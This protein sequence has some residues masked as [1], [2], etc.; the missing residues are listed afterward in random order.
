MRSI[1]GRS[2]RTPPPD[3]TVYQSFTGSNAPRVRGLECDRMNARY[4]YLQ[5]DLIGSEWTSLSVRQALQTASRELFG[6]A[7]AALPLDVLLVEHSPTGGPGRALV[8]V[9]CGSLVKTRAALT[10]AAPRLRL[11]AGRGAPSLQAL[12]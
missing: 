7:G 5:L 6:E 8:R 11:R 4:F 1:A 12:L 3:R 9:P 10:V 2:E